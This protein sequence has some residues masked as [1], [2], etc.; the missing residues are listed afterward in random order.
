M[1]ENL[2]LPSL[3]NLRLILELGLLISLLTLWQKTG[4][5][6]AFANSLID[7]W[8]LDQTGLKKLTWG[9]GLFFCQSGT[10][11]AIVVGSS[12][13]PI[14]DRLRLAAPV[15]AFLLD[16]MAS[17]VA[18]ILMLNAWPAFLL[19]VLQDPR[20]AD[21]PPE[22]RS[23]QLIWQSLP[24]SF[25]SIGMIVLA[26]ALAWNWL[27]RLEKH[28]SRSRQDDTY[29]QTSHTDPTMDDEEKTF[30][31]NAQAK[32]FLYP[33]ICMLM[34]IILSF[35]V[36]EE[37]HLW[38]G[39]SLA[40]LLSLAMARHRG[41]PWRVL[42]AALLVGLKKTLIVTIIFIGVFFTWLLTPFLPALQE[43]MQTFVSNLSPI[44]VPLFLQIIAMTIAFCIGTS[45][46]TFFLFIPSG[47][48]LAWYVASEQNLE[49]AAWF[50]TI[51]FAAMK[52]GAVFGD[53]SSPLSDTTIAA[54]LTSG[55]PL[56][57]HVRRQLPL[58][59]S[60][61]AIA[62]ASWTSICVFLT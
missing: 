26:W 14:K 57:L 16:A 35:L 41:Q 43:S 36:F 44:L 23:G 21:L 8:H 5:A 54:A 24:L 38:L 13:R 39:F 15:Y 62:A 3:A 53:Q 1:L 37:A 55:C 17:P 49:H 40:T 20:L 27:P 52:D 19:G 48:A 61:S 28:L 9:M 31:T 46:G 33:W 30:S 45:W 34:T 56:A 4:A 42:F 6:L 29:V 12:L 47:L 10:F 59:L 58:T 51:C 60:M 22:L 50:L 7:R 25:Y 32:D 2:S 18:S 11:S